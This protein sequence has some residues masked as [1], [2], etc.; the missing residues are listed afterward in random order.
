MFLSM[1]GHRFERS[2]ERLARSPIL[3]RY[4]SE[5]GDCSFTVHAATYR[6][7]CVVRGL[8]LDP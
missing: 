7:Q 1:I 2:P 4:R 8:G 5:S 6:L 3:G